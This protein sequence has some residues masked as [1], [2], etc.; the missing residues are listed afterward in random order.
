MSNEAEARQTLTELTRARSRARQAL[1]AGWF[2]YLVFGLLCLGAAALGFISDNGEGSG[3]YWATATPL[4]LVIVWQF[5]DRLEHEA[6][7]FWRHEMLSGM[8]FLAMLAGAL[9]LGFLAEGE[10]SSIGPLVPVGLGLLAICALSRDPID[11]FAGAAIWLVVIA[12]V[13]VEPADPAQ[14]AML[15]EGAVLIA[16]A[17]AGRA[18]SHRSDR[19]STATAEPLRT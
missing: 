19:A 14:L 4:A 15:G 2:A 1:D 18:R 16:A 8:I 5:F 3:V 13:A 6:G 7:I 17:L 9:A 12:L 11:G 10:L